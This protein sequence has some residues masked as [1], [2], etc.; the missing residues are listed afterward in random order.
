MK[1]YGRGV[2]ILLVTLTLLGLLGIGLPQQVRAKSV[3]VRLLDTLRFDPDLI[4]A[5]PGEELVLTFVNAGSI[6][7][8]FTLFAQRD[9]DV[10]LDV[11]MDLQDYNATH[12]KLVDEWLGA[13]EERTVTITAPSEAGRYVFVC[14][15]LGHAAGGMHGE[16]IVGSPGAGIAPVVIGVI[17]AVVVAVVVVAFFLLRRPSA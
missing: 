10:S 3:E 13:G 14:M 11:E 6:V 16:L 4:T 9:P 12:T 17:V 1:W 2:A 7:H 15:V 8:S 5:D